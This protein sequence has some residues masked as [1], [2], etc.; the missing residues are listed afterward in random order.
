MDPGRIPRSDRRAGSRTRRQRYQRSHLPAQLDR[1][2]QAGIV[3]VF[4]A[5]HRVQR[6]RRVTEGQT[7]WQHRQPRRRCAG[8]A[9][10]RRV[11]GCRA[12]SHA[13]AG[14][15][16]IAPRDFVDVDAWRLVLGSFC[17]PPRRFGFVL[18]NQLQG[19]SS[20]ATA[21]VLLSILNNIPPVPPFF[22]ES[23]LSCPSLVCSVCVGT[24]VRADGT[25]QLVLAFWRCCSHRE[26]LS[27]LM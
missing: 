22:R 19:Y 8:A 14:Q 3:A 1:R 6:R 17:F 11:G 5:V 12:V 18:C 25:G 13:G 21:L 2:L 9:G 7:V 16:P 23:P 4:D 15:N 26:V 27:R 24:R 10:A 20:T